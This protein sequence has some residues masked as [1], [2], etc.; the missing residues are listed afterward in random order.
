MPFSP[1]F[2][3]KNHQTF[4][5][6]ISSLVADKKHLNF[7]GPDDFERKQFNRP[8][9]LQALNIPYG[10]EDQCDDCRRRN[11]TLIDMK[12]NHI[13][14]DHQI[15]LWIVNQPQPT[16]L[17]DGTFYV[18]VRDQHEHHI[19]LIVSNWSYVTTTNELKSREDLMEVLNELLPVGSM[20]FLFE[21]FLT[22][23]QIDGQICLRCIAPNLEFILLERRKKSFVHEKLDD[24]RER[25]NKAYIR[26]HSQLAL[27]YYTFGINRILTMAESIIAKGKNKRFF[28]N[29]QYFPHRNR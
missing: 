11:I 29:N 22:V 3:L 23:C 9:L 18:V 15:S 19:R 24:L 4:H 2:V 28:F 12:L 20:I 16:N 25:G 27:D 26:G 5:D 21:P 6:R 14:E 13:H 8:V 10:H 1:D 7:F 17:V